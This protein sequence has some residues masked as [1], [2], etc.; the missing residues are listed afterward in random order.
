MKNSFRIGIDLGGSKIECILL[1]PDGQEIKRERISAPQGSYRSTVEAV[2]SLI[3]NAEKLTETTPSVGMGIPGS[4]SKK[5]NLVRN[6]NSTWLIGKPLKTDIENI[7]ERPILLENDANCFAVS[8]AVDGKGMQEQIVFGIILGSGVGAGLVIDNKLCKGANDICGEWGH[9]PIPWPKHSE[10]PGDSCY[11]GKKG[12]LETFLSGPALEKLYHKRNP[13]RLSP[14]Q[15]AARA[16]SGDIDAE[17][18]LRE[19]ENRLARALSQVINIL[20]PHVIVI[21]GGLSNIQRL[22]QNVPKIWEKYIFSENVSTRLL[23]AA[24]GDSSGVR[25]AAWLWN[26]QR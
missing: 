10:L 21:G 12:C 16:L 4:L 13:E 5:T 20:D 6:A 26:Q 19:Y 24:H 22:Y 17:T 25:G 15:I 3:R 11:C 9:N 2:I 23:P 1:A 8:E 18:T 7:L 14:P